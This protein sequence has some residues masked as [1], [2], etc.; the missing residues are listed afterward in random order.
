MKRR[1]FLYFLAAG[2]VAVLG[3]LGW[4]KPARWAEAVR[5][6]RYPGPVVPLDKGAMKQPGPWAG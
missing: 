6:K 4:E 2:A 3:G 1:H 5:A